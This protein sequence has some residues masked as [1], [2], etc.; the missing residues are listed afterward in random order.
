MVCIPLLGLLGPTI[1]PELLRLLASPHRHPPPPDV[2]LRGTLQSIGRRC[3]CICPNRF[4][5]WYVTYFLS[6]PFKL[7]LFI[8]FGTLGTSLACLLFAI[9]NP[10]APY[11][12]YGFPS[13]AITVFGADF[14]FASGTLF[15]A[16]V[17]EPHEQS[18]AGALFQTMTQV[19]C[20]T[21][22]LEYFADI[23]AREQIGTSLG[24]TVTTVIFDRVTQ[25]KS[26]GDPAVIAS[27]P[28]AS[29]QA[30]QW[31][32]F[33]FGVLCMYILHT[34]CPSYLTS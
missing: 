32:S 10:N 27:P 22:L 13:A 25:Q 8:A 30:A 12:A 26:R 11:W 21:A 33:A 15:I 34:I 2:H 20:I 29:Y 9:I 31:G 17:A 7:I 28:L 4:P 3:R 6:C 1:L 18:L 16:K 19:R 14:V 5:S 23:R 24:V